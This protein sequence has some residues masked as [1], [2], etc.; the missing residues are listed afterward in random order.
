MDY[1]ANKAYAEYTKNRDGFKN[2][3]LMKGIF[4]ADFIKMKR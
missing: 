2:Y 1:F 3:D 4:N